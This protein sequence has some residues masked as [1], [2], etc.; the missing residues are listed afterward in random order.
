MAAKVSLKVDMPMPLFMQ[1]KRAAERRSVNAA[2]Q[3]VAGNDGDP[4]SVELLASAI[5]VGTLRGYRVADVIGHST[6]H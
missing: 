5:L 4:V 1:L 2:G 3:I 6:G